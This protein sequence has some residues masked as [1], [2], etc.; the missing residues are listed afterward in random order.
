MFHYHFIDFY[1]RT[2]NTDTFNHHLRKACE[3]SGIAYHSSHKIRFYAASSAFTGDNIVEIGRQ[4]GQKHVST[5]MRYLR[6]VNQTDDCS[7]LFKAL[8]RAGAKG[9][10]ALQNKALRTVKKQVTQ[11]F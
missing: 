7:S 9:A 10:E 11:S 5:T 6:N 4:M 2:G 3:A 1:G 8:G